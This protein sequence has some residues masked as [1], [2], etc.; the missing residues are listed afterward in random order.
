L[1]PP[2]HLVLPGLHVPPHAVPSAVHAYMQ[3]VVARGGQV[4][5]RQDAPLVR[6]PPKQLA[7]RHT[8]GGKLQ[9]VALVPLHEPAHTPSPTQG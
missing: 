5:A 4:P 2:T 7:A 8:F 1:V 3:V 6:M 9:A